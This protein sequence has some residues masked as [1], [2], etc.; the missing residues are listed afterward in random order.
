LSDTVQAFLDGKPVEGILASADG[1]K[2]L[3]IANKQGQVQFVPWGERL[4]RTDPTGGRA[5]GKSD[6]EH[7]SSVLGRKEFNTVR[8]SINANIGVVRRYDAVLSSLRDAAEA[9]NIQEVVGQAGKTITMIDNFVRGLRGTLQAFIPGD[10]FFKDTNLIDRWKG[11]A[12]NPNAA[13]WD[14]IQLPEWTRN[15][16]AQ[17]QNYRAQIIEL[18]YLSARAAEPSNR[19]LSDNDIQNALKRLGAE[20]G[21][22]AVMFR[23]SMEI[24][25]SGSTEVDDR[26]K[27][28]Y[29]AYQRRDG[30]FISDEAI[31]RIL[32]GALLGEYRAGIKALYKKFDVTIT[33]DNRAIFGKPIDADVNP[34]VSA[35]QVEASEAKELDDAFDILFK[36]QRE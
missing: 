17:A 14:L 35:E 34:V 30:S 4:T 23:R 19:G 7:V 2:G 27:G 26:L 32:G 8:A 9:G 21:N 1:V 22:P 16:A 36:E 11:H 24:V 10:T 12:N 25:A 3:Q 13:I 5:P 6:D 29:T 18:A 31:D 15:S 28:H 33:D 20:S